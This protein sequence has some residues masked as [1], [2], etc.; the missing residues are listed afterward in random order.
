MDTFSRH[1]RLVHFSSS[2]EHA[3]RKGHFHDLHNDH[4][5]SASVAE[6]P[7]GDVDV[8][9]EFLVGNGLSPNLARILRAVGITDR[10]RMRMLGTLPDTEL[11]RVDQQL[12]K[13][14]MDFVALVL[15]REGLRRCARAGIQ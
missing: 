3:T 12:V 2:E 6:V 4:D 13:Q 1:L 8:V 15:V 14:G 5:I 10:K 9:V 7:K 11:D